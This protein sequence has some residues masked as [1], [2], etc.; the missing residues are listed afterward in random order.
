MAT[1]AVGDIQGCYEPLIKLLGTAGFDPASDRLWCVGDLINRGPASLQVLR[2][3]RD[4]GDGV[5]VV[6]GNHD[7][8]FLAIHYGCRRTSSKDTL[9]ELLEAPDRVELAEWLRAK[10]L[11]HHEIIATQDG[12]QSFLMVHAGVAP[13]WSLKKTLR[14]A[15]E[16]SQALQG[17][18]FRDYFE[19]MYGDTPR[20]WR[21]SLSGH[22]RLRIITNYLTRMRFC[23]ARGTLDLQAKEGLDQTPEGLRPWFDFE[24]LTPETK[25]LFGHWAA[26]EGKTGRP[27]VIALDTG[28]VWGRQ[29]SM[30]RL[31]DSAMFSVG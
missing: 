17:P 30:M 24:Q 10:P 31:E 28:C 1:Y 2:F 6:L 11:A 26:L 7:L 27:G 23:D 9:Q 12:P 8:H 3:L 19:H 29:L 20:R 14:L 22:K 15:G 25:I 16:V 5:S 21:G 18:D 4:L 13:V